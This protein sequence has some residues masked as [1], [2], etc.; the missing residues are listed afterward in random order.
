MIYL[1]SLGD[2]LTL[3]D[4]ELFLIYAGFG[5]LF[6]FIIMQVLLL[7]YL[8]HFIKK[9]LTLKF[10]KEDFNWLYRIL[11]I[12]IFITVFLQFDFLDVVYL[13]ENINVKVDGVDFSFSGGIIQQ[14]ATH[15][16]NFVAFGI[17]AKIVAGM[18]TTHKSLTIPGKIGVILAS[19]TSSSLTFN[20]INQSNQM[21]RAKVFYELHQLGAANNKICM[22]IKK[23]DIFTNLN[24]SQIE[25]IS[26]SLTGKSD[27]NL[28]VFKGYLDHPFTINNNNTNINNNFSVLFKDKFQVS[29]STT[30]ERGELRIITAI[31][32]YKSDTLSN[33]FSNSYPINNPLEN[34]DLFIIENKS[35]LIDILSSSYYLNLIIVYFCIMLAIIFAFKFVININS[36]SDRIKSLPLGKHIYYV[37]NKFIIA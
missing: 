30:T 23:M 5:F 29:T 22:N 11:I 10:E 28:S 9:N 13:D 4:L 33:I 34:G 6:T 37:L 7:G 32:E 20:I 21:I 15:F 16:G 24:D 25:T 1:I 12:F 17:S 2:T 36:Y 27:S 19:G 31:E 8:G 14:I 18:V 3:N 35:Q 26:A